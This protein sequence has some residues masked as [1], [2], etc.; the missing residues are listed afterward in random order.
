[1]SES[2]GSRE[3]VQLKEQV[4]PMLLFESPWSWTPYFVGMP[5]TGPYT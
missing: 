4:A 2:G 5:P 1:M 3:Q